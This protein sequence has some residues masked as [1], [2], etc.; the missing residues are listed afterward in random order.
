MIS[1]ISHVLPNGWTLT[2]STKEGELQHFSE[3]A[4]ITTASTAKGLRLFIQ[5]PVVETRS[6]F[7][8]FQIISI[9]QP[10]G[11]GSLARKLSPLPPHIA[12]SENRQLYAELQTNEIGQ[13]LIPATSLCRLF[14]VLSHRLSKRTCSMAISNA[15]TKLIASNCIIKTE[16]WPGPDMKYIGNNKW[17]YTTTPNQQIHFA[18]ASTKVND[19]KTLT[20][21][22]VIELP[23][24]CTATA[25]HWILP[26]NIRHYSEQDETPMATTRPFTFLDLPFETTFTE[27]T[28]INAQTP[29]IDLDITELLKRNAAEIEKTRCHQPHSWKQ[30]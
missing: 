9:P 4:S 19:I 16:K 28:P 21:T 18:C 11:N 8:L 15:D 1:K 3:E 5:F 20:T 24:D 13:C 10:L 6:N 2:A 29:Q 23:D 26:A 25:D 27:E 12:I 7:D 30:K 14:V 17:V 22:S